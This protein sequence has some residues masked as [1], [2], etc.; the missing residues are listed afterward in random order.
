[1]RYL[2][3]NNRPGQLQMAAVAAGCV[4]CSGVFMQ[5]LTNALRAAL[6]APAG[7]GD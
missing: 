2:D 5:V 4:T 1:M 6:L 3:L 7:S